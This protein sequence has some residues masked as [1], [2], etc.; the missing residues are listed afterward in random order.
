MRSFSRNSLKNRTMGNG[1]TPLRTKMRLSPTVVAVR[2][3]LW[4]G[5][6]EA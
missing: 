2:G 1:W 6:G 3:A 5:G 4:G